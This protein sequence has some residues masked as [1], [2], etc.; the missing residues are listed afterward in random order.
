MPL[1]EASSLP[2]NFIEERASGIATLVKPNA[3]L[4]AT[5]NDVN[6]YCMDFLEPEWCGFWNSYG[7]GYSRSER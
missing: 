4:P 7:Y 1:E 5:A 3:I 2:N 6:D